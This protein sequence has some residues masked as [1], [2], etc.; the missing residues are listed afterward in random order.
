MSASTTER[1]GQDTR[2][3]P[4]ATDRLGLPGAPTC[5]AAPAAPLV[6]ALPLTLPITSAYALDLAG[7]PFRAG[8]LAAAAAA[9]ALVVG[10]V[11]WRGAGRV[12]G[13]GGRPGRAR[14]PPGVGGGRGVGGGAGRAGAAAGPPGRAAGDVRRHPRRRPP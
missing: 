5:D 12:A 10:L 2:A 1:P 9:Q 6:R 8:S 11:L 7:L 3:R 4:R 13:R 14:R